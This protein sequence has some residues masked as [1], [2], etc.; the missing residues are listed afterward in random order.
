ME[1]ITSWVFISDACPWLRTR[2]NEPT[3]KGTILFD[4]NSTISISPVNFQ[5]GCYILFCLLW[6]ISLI[7]CLFILLSLFLLCFRGLPK[8]NGCCICIL[9]LVKWWQIYNS[10]FCLLGHNWL[11]SRVEFSSTCCKILV[12]HRR[13]ITFCVQRLLVQ[14]KLGSQPY[15]KS[16][17]SWSFCLLLFLS[18]LFAYQSLGKPPHLFHLSWIFNSFVDVMV[19]SSTMLRE[20]SL[21][22]LSF[23]L[24]FEDVIPF[25][26][27]AKLIC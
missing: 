11:E 16:S 19:S 17:G 8:Y 22:S 2:R 26:W 12:P 24:F 13:K 21:L 6:I 9:V 1:I 23:T 3:I 20:S 27:L 18:F 10:F 14:L 4:E 5:Y 7:R 15:S 25:E